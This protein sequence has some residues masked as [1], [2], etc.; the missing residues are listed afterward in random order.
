M[1]TDHYE[2]KRFFQK[3]RISRQKHFATQL[4]LNLSVHRWAKPNHNQSISFAV[5]K[6]TH[7][8]RFS[9]RFD[10]CWID[11]S[12]N[13]CTNIRSF[14]SANILNTN[15][16]LICLSRYLFRQDAKSLRIDTELCR[17]QNN[18]C[19]Q[20]RADLCVTIV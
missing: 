3:C 5:L 12:E 18:N 13:I 10:K 4:C 1:Q 8:Y 15:S 16:C 2:S 19:Q 17:Q 7:F 11:E 9:T 6:C 20:F 14:I